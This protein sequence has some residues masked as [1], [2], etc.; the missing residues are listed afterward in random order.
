M[1]SN[2]DAVRSLWHVFE[3]GG[4][5]AMSPYVH[6][7]SEWRPASADGRVLRGAEE[8]REHF[9][10]LAAA[11]VQIRAR[12]DEFEDFGDTVLVR[13]ALRVERFGAL[14]ESTMIWTYRF[15][16]GQV[17]CARAFHS[18]AEALASIR[19]ASAAAP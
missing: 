11:G 9:R 19:E 15:R 8:V 16:D 14:S 5:D 12:L 2:V 10:S 13:G 3:H 7:D 4:A 17:L 18:R 6:P 1:S